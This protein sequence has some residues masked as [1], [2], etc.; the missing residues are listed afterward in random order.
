MRKGAIVGDNGGVIAVVSTDLP[1]GKVEFS[2]S[3]AQTMNGGAV[4]VNPCAGRLTF[5]KKVMTSRA[6]QECV[7][8]AECVDATLRR[9]KI[10][11]KMPATILIMADYRCGEKSWFFNIQK[12][13]AAMLKCNM[14]S[15]EFDSFMSD[16][17]EPANVFEAEL[18]RQLGNG[19]IYVAEKWHGRYD[20]EYVYY[21][22]YPGGELKSLEW[23]DHEADEEELEEMIST[24]SYNL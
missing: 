6:A 9:F 22:A 4:L 11:S 23:L 5:A 1:A 10:A 16:E 20:V 15:K 17:E 12:F 14:T 19:A 2:T 18:V 3:T 7:A 24:A 13:R 21:R 8:S